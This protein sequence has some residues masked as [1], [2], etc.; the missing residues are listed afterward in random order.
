[1]ALRVALIGCGPLGRR[2][3]ELIAATG[4]TVLVAFDA[5]SDA[6]EEFANRTGAR[7]APTLDDAVTA[8]GVDAIV[9]C[10]GGRNGS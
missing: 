5:N 1:M 2:Y 8:V 9:V 10:L 4:S 7:L 3:A 6:F